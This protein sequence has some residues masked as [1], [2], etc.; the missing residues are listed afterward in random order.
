ME[1]CPTGW[2]TSTALAE[3]GG[4]LKLAERFLSPLVCILNLCIL[5]DHGGGVEYEG[6]ERVCGA[7]EVREGCNGIT[8]L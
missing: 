2:Q 5:V 1:L 4:E 7:A 6:T 3:R 8:V